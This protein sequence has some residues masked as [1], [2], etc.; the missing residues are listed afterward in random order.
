MLPLLSE[1]MERT[2]HVLRT[3]PTVPDDAAAKCNTLHLAPACLRH[4]RHDSIGVFLIECA[5]LFE[6]KYNGLTS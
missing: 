6:Y 2:D 3:C 4:Y 5:A 1:V